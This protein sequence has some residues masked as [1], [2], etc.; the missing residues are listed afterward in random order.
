MLQGTPLTSG[1][2]VADTAVTL[3]LTED[4]FLTMLSDNIEMAHG[5]FKMV[6]DR[7]GGAA[8]AAVLPA[9]VDAAGQW[10]ERVPPERVPALRATPLFARATTAQLLKVAAIARETPFRVGDRVRPPGAPSI[11]IVTAG[12]LAVTD[13]TGTATA[14]RGDT[15]GAYAA[16]AATPHETGVAVLEEGVAL[17]IDAPDLLEILADDPDLVR[18]MFNGLLQAA[19]ARA[20]IESPRPVATIM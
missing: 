20:A 13:G 8:A 2:E 1:I 9:V 12:E 18:A 15:I 6:L 14:R 5:L 19:P 11:T 16:L 3:S 10:L 4:E 7:R 17:R